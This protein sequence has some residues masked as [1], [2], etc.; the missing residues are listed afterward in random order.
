MADDHR[1]TDT[2]TVK[3]VRGAE[4]RRFYRNRLQI[5]SNRVTLHFSGYLH[6]TPTIFFGR[7]PLY[8]TLKKTFSL[9]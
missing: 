5:Y 1:W 7:L 8:P 4:R 2:M 3:T 6:A 9:K